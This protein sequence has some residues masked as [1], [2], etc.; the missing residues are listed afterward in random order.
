MLIALT[1]LSGG[2]SFV[3]Y[4]DEQYNILMGSVIPQ[5]KWRKGSQV[6]QCILHINETKYI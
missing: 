4:A 3:D 5:E 1:C 6:L 2:S